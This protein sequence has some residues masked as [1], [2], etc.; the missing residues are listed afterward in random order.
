MGKAEETVDISFK[1]EK[2]RFLAHYKLVKKTQKDTAKL[3]QILQGI[4]DQSLY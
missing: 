4:L 1:Q 3:L 2:E